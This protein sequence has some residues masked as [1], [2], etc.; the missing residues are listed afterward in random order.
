MTSTLTGNKMHIELSDP[1][2]LFE[3]SEG[4][5]A[6]CIDRTCGGRMAGEIHGE[7]WLKRTLY[8]Q[9]MNCC[10]STCHRTAKEVIEVYDEASE[11]YL[12]QNFITIYDT[13]LGYTYKWPGFT[14]SITPL[15]QAAQKDGYDPGILMQEMVNKMMKIARRNYL[16][17]I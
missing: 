11:T 3:I 12:I 1:S 14:Q 7:F 15:I 17:Q 6:R 8:R 10:C 16:E 9:W 4:K 2:E 13:T 5:M